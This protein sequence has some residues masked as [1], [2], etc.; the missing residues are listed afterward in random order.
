LPTNCSALVLGEPG[1]GQLYE[2][3]AELVSRGANEPPARNI[4]LGTS[5]QHYEYGQ[6]VHESQ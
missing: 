2:S 3:V 4:A 6:L 5:Q 1:E